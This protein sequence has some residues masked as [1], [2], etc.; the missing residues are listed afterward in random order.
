M[1]GALRGESSILDPILSVLT[2]LFEWMNAS[3]LLFFFNLVETLDHCNFILSWGYISC[4]EQYKV[5]DGLF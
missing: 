1:L 3:G 2:S 4:I 5:H